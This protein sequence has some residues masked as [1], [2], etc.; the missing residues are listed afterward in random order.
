[1]W[2]RRLEMIQVVKD[3]RLKSFD[4]Q[5]FQLATVTINQ[6][7]VRSFLLFEKKLFFLN[8]RGRSSLFPE[9]SQIVMV[10]INDFELRRH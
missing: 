10:S 5:N 8:N 7:S 4:C 3:L 1:M 2:L 9:R 6:T